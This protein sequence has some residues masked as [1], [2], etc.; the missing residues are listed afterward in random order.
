[1]WLLEIFGMVVGVVG[2][3]LINVMLPIA[4]IAASSGFLV[5]MLSAYG[6]ICGAIGGEILDHLPYLKHAIPSGFYYLANYISPESAEHAKAALYGN[7]DKVGAVFGFIGG[8]FKA[9]LSCITEE[10]RK[11]KLEWWEKIKRNMKGAPNK[12]EK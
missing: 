9:S 11:R 3:V 1:M 10:E 6:A 2:L 7:L 4:V 12:A 5:L 8:F